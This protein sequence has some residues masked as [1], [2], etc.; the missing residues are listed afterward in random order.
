[1]EKTITDEYCPKCGACAYHYDVD[2]TSFE[3]DGKGHYYV[4]YVCENSDCKNR[5]RMY[6]HFKYEITDKYTL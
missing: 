6:Y 5:F 4:D 1:M 2:E 3:P